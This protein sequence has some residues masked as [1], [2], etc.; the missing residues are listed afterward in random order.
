MDSQRLESYLMAIQGEMEETNHLLTQL[1]AVFG[2]FIDT[3]ESV[4]D[5][6][7]YEVVFRREELQ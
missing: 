5:D 1:V 3:L 2:A 7:V 4:R 6:E